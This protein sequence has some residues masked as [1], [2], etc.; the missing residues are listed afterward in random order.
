MYQAD[1][2]TIK[3]GISGLVLMEAAGRG[4]ATHIQDNWP[5]G[6]CLVLCGP[7]NNGGDGYVV[8]RY[9]S[10]A[11][12]Q[13]D[14]FSVTDP[15]VLKGDAASM[16]DRW[17]G[18]VQEI[19]SPDFKNHD[20]VVDA[21]FGAGFSRELPADISKLLSSI[22]EAKIPVVAVDIPSGVNGDTGG[23]DPGAI[24][25]ATTVSFFL[26]K[27][28]HF[29]YPGRGYCGHLEIVDIGID[30][31]TLE[32]ISPQAQQNDPC[33]WVSYLRRADPLD[34]KYSRGHTA[35]VGGG[36]SSTG[37]ARL[38]ARASLRAGAGATTIISPPGAL[39]TYAAALEAV[40]V[41][42]V[43]DEETF[44]DW[45][46]KKRIGTLL[47]GPGNGL[48]DRTRTLA[49]ASLQS[50]ATVVLDADALTVFKN[51]PETLFATIKS[52]T[53]GACILTPHEAE[54]SRL[55]GLSGSKLE[56]ARAAAILSGAIILLKGA[57]T[58][59][60]A[61]DG[62][63]IINHNAPPYLATAGSGDVL[64]G[65]ICGLL[66]SGMPAFLAAAAAAWIH[67]DAGNSL[68]P[69]MIAEDIEAEIPAILAGFS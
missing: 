29:L 56:R 52:K 65:I 28:G 25:A 68:G 27:P 66:S 13:V 18:G 23:V 41:A 22:A 40:M 24:P 9:L 39:T 36:I 6:R 60:A 34:Q 58:V 1:N 8:A 47:V 17:K 19:E 3:S 59:I 54:F 2:L 61:P 20:L 64:G 38:A 43:A 57:D 31:K 4:I 16:R 67:G 12:W 5:A 50:N 26:A 10:E 11:G 21:I 14:L 32:A 37:A 63:A 44:R 69:G 62:Q 49:M 35:I 51:D 53:E 45:I 48:G 30:E 7:G 42:S 55:F 33:L 15:N 46:S